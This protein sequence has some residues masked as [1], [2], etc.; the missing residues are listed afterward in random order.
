MNII[1]TGSLGNISRQLTTTLTAKGHRV[2]VISHSPGRADAI[3]ELQATP[4]IGSVEDPE[5]LLQTFDKADAVYTMIPPNYSAGDIKEYIRRTGKTYANA[6]EQAGVR[7]VVNLSGI[8]AHLPEGLGPAGAN[9]YVESRFNALKDTHVLHLRPGMFYTNFFGA[10]DMIRHQHM[11]GNNF[12]ETVRMVLS[13]PRDIAAAAATAL[14]TLSFMGKNVLYVAGDEKNGK[15][16]S[17]ILG[18]AI[19]LPDLRWVAFP[20]EA[21]LQGLM[22]SGMTREMASVYVIEI[23]IELRNG[24][25]FDDYRKHSEKA[26]GQTSF[27]DFAREFAFAYAQGH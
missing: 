13:H 26:V 4:A 8:G 27:S 18:Q 10:M 15:E 22:Q 12:D 17:A 7:H 2:T 24:T 23:G 21:L 3:R 9:H 19:G 25:L 20:D 16:L 1:I 14:D 11:I 6:I 5:F